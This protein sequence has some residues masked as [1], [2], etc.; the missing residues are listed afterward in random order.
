MGNGNL[1][2]VFIALAILIVVFLLAYEVLTRAVNWRKV[3]DV[4]CGAFVFD[5]GQWFLSWHRENGMAS[6][7]CG[8]LGGNEAVDFIERLS[9]VLAIL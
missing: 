6:I 8:P 9:K 1:R 7:R 5:M 2:A 3:F 4:R